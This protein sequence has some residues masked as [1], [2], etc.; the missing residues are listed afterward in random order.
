[1]AKA[2]AP[3]EMP[4]L[5]H[6]AIGWARSTRRSGGMYHAHALGFTSCRTIQL[7]RFASEEPRHVGDMQY[8]GVCPK[9]FKLGGNA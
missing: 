8:W 5:P 9:C 3:K 1:M 7:D 4:N 2:I 6:E